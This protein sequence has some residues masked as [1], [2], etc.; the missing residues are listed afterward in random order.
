MDS[1]DQTPSHNKD[2]FLDLRSKEAA[3][4]GGV[5]GGDM[6]T[7]NTSGKRGNSRF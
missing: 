6:G 1:R 7:W 5:A 2:E 4:E 3:G